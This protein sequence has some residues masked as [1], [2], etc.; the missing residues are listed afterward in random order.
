[1]IF[2]KY[3]KSPFSFRQGFL[4][5]AW[6]CVKRLWR[7]LT[8]RLRWLGKLVIHHKIISAVV[9]AIILSIGS[10]F[11]GVYKTTQSSFS[12]LESRSNALFDSYEK[13]LNFCKVYVKNPYKL[14]LFE[15]FRLADL[16]DRM[17]KALTNLV[18]THRSMG[19]LVSRKT[20]LAIHE[21]TCWT[22]N[23]LKKSMYICGANLLSY[24]G[25]Q[26]WKTSLINQINKNK[27]QHQTLYQTTK[28]AIEFFF[29]DPRDELY[30]K[31]N[32]TC[33]LNA[34]YKYLKGSE[35]DKFNS[36]KK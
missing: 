35:S 33:N 3:K 26:N 5:I 20:Y 22:D 27:I 15:E 36:S 14:T 12:A 10:G 28:D 24:K 7:F 21:Q 32:P 34:P 4:V 25:T 18:N 30:K 31:P 13:Q 11:L 29:S 6:L 23:M 19:H 17:E 8:S 9:S 1:M 16:N 2:K